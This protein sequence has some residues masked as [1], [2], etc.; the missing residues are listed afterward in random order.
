MNCKS[1]HSLIYDEL[2]NKLSDAQKAMLE[3]HVA[4]CRKCQLLYYA[5][6]GAIEGLKTLPLPEAP[7]E[8]PGSI[9][10]APKKTTIKTIEPEPEDIPEPPL[11]PPKI[12]LAVQMI[13]LAA[14]LIIMVL[15]LILPILEPVTIDL[16]LAECPPP[17]LE[18][19][20]YRTITNVR[21]DTV[22][23]VDYIQ[24][25]PPDDGDQKEI[26]SFLSGEKAGSK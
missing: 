4:K 22:C 6:A 15:N 21:S 18:Q 19:M 20:K 7:K 16:P 3:E 5:Q 10:V 26:F 9:L 2:K 1:C 14:A 13:F 17:G 25:Q 24:A 8:L 12:S 11:S 23:A